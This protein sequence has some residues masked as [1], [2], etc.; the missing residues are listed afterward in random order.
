MPIRTRPIAT[1]H[2]A[3]REPEDERDACKREREEEGQ[4]VA[5]R[6]KGVDRET[7]E[8]EQRQ[9]EKGT[10]FDLELPQHEREQ[11]ELSEHDEEVE[12]GDLSLLNHPVRG[13]RSN[14][15]GQRYFHGHGLPRS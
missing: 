8:G 9:A 5:E 13:L 12:S 14:L 3:V 1:S 11:T 2:C 10:T 4:P 15:P 7:R 6:Q